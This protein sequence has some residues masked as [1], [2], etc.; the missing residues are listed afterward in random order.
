MSSCNHCLLQSLKRHAKTGEIVTVIPSIP[1]KSEL[2]GFD[3]YRHPVG[4]DI[5]VMSDA[6]RQPFWVAWFMAL[7]ER[8]AC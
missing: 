5:K 8:C 4:I 6:E 2:L 3:A 1:G 7:P